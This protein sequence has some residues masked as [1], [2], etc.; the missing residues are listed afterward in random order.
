MS[1]SFFDPDN[2]VFSFIYTVLDM[3]VL[4]LLWFLC[5]IPVVTIGPACAGLYYATVKSVRRGRGVAAKEFWKG[6][7]SNIKQ[8]IIMEIVLILF[9]VMMAAGDVVILFFLGD[10]QLFLWLLLL[11]KLFVLLG[12]VCWMCPVITRFDQRFK[13]IIELSLY[14]LVH[15]FWSTILLIVIVLIAAAC[16]I[17]EPLLIALVPSVA[18]LVSS[19]VVEP[20]LKAISDT[21]S[22]ADDSSVDRWYLE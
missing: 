11:L 21:S 12:T 13:K 9:M 3:L 8:A 19:F 10:S 17:V 16:M 4:N 15:H 6:F 14:L 22:Q 18:A 1:S 2:P 7:R 20:A 5:C